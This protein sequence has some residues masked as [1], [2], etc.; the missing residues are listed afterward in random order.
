MRKLSKVGRVI[1]TPPDRD[2]LGRGTP[3]KMRVVSCSFDRPYC[4]R[5]VGSLDAL[6][7][8][9]LLSCLNVQSALL[10]AL[11][12]RLMTEAL[13]PDFVSTAVVESLGQ[14]ML[15]EWSHAV[16]SQEEKYGRGRLLPRHFKIIDEY[17]AALSGQA[18][19]VSDI[20]AACGFSERYFAKLFREQT[21]QTI[22][23][24]LKSA[25]I[26]KAQS[27]LLQTELPLKEIA[28]RLGF[29]TPANF[30]DAFRAATGETPGRFR[31]TN[32]IHA[33]APRHPT[34]R[35]GY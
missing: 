23:H 35:F 30:S 34:Q 14:A 4:E 7:K 27:Y 3:G 9:Q 32:R 29:S 13:H 22:G 26:S 6:S 16:L 31:A 17:L 25:Q 20:A 28:H 8:T 19:S 2:V 21:H 10:P 12:S 18:P 1:F 5:I 33:A 11:F 15:V 24:F